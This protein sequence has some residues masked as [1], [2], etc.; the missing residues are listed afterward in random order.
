MTG[1][2][3]QHGVLWLIAWMICTKPGFAST[4]PLISEATSSEFGAA[5]DVPFNCRRNGKRSG[6]IPPA[7]SQAFRTLLTHRAPRKAKE[8][9]TYHN[10]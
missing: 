2:E 8:D 3:A 5:V 6:R 4:M 10:Y 7:A 9:G 1:R